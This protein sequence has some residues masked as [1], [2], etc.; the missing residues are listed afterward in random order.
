M[1]WIGLVV[2]LLLHM[3][4]P[5]ISAEPHNTARNGEIVGIT[6]PSN[7]IVHPNETVSSYITLHNL[8]TVNQEFTI[9]VVD[10]P[11]ILTTVNLPLSEV[12][13]PNHLKQLAFGISANASATY[14]TH[15]VKFNVASDYDETFSRSVWMNVTVA[16][17][18]NLKFGSENLTTL[19]VDE[20]VRT[21]V[22]VNITNNA[23]FPDNVTFDLYSQ[24][25]WNWGWSM[26]TNEQGNAYVNLVPDSLSYVYLWVDVPAVLD[27]MPLAGTGPRF[28]LTGISGLD[29]ATTSWAFDLIMNEKRNVSID[30][31]EQDIALAPGQDGRLEISIRNVGNTANKVN[32]TLQGLDELGNALNG[33]SASDRFN[34]S[35]WTVALFGG[36]EDVFLQPNES[37]TVEIGIQSPLEFSGEMNVEL[38]VFAKG[39]ES[40]FK[41]ARVKATINRTTSATISSIQDGCMNLVSGIPCTSSVT[42]KNT[43]NSYNT[44]NLRIGEVSDEFTVL[45]PQGSLLVQPNQ[46]KTFDNMFID[47]INKTLAFTQGEI[48]IELIDDTGAVLNTILIPVRAAPVIQ[49]T[50]GT[51]E[52]SIS[53]KNRL[54]VVFEVRNDGNAIDGFVVQLQSSHSVPMGLIPPE[55]AVYE[56]EDESPRSFQLNGVPLGANLTLRAWIDLPSDQTSNGTV[57][58]NTTITSIFAPESQMFVF[59]SKGDYLG[60]PWQDDEAVE[61][62]RDWGALG[63]TAWAYTKAWSGVILAIIFSGLIIYKSLIDRQRRL[64]SEGVLPYQNVKTDATDWMKKYESASESPE[65]TAPVVTS[66]QISKDAFEAEFRR[67][68]G[69]S[70]PAATP[71]DATLRDAAALVLDTRTE[72]ATLQKAD[73]LLEQ[74][75]SEGAAQPHPLNHSLKHEEQP[76]TLTVRNDPYEV[77]SE[78][79]TTVTEMAQ[80]PLPVADEDPEDD[81][82]F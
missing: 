15:Q 35:G 22:A 19:T 44:F 73:N 70:S 12:L 34:Y 45:A 23:S 27:G 31:V 76:S 69:N 50:L 11:T 1:R 66:Q 75:Q 24:S 42:V 17:Y 46:E 79:E 47:V 51:V 18:S 55:G 52:E 40:I 16:P 82:E 49:W 61:E 41:T 9:S 81:L 14:T 10:M 8:V 60:T 20:K 56:E 2:L 32:I 65:T 59:T 62:G 33:Y 57:Y 6:A 5:V 25:G 58:I 63:A 38:R 28:T 43:G 54:S 29:K 77:I 3:I 71:V 74:I 4:S 39:A 72:Q 13:V 37:R 78:P 30:E 64:D 36:L 80:V 26:N 7:V 21:G 48:E 68:S 67:Q 53:P